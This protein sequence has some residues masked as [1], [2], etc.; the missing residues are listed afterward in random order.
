[1]PEDIGI[2]R[3]EQVGPNTADRTSPASVSS[4]TSLK[5]RILHTILLLSFHLNSVQTTTTF[6]PEHPY[7]AEFGN[8]RTVKLAKLAVVYNSTNDQV[9]S[10][11]SEEQGQKR[12]RLQQ[13]SDGA[14]CED[15]HRFLTPQSVMANVRQVNWLRFKQYRS[16]A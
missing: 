16:V 3:L 10:S 12:G 8:R 2:V 1:M 13:A 6:V 9:D 14:H 11:R 15:V 4:C 7:S 5:D